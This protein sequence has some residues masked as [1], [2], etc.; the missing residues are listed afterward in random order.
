MRTPT[1]NMDATAKDQL[2]INHFD[3]RSALRLQYRQCGL[4]RHRPQALPELAD[5]GASQRAN[6]GRRRNWP[7]AEAARHREPQPPSATFLRLHVRLRE[8]SN[9]SSSNKAIEKA[10]SYDEA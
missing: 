4:R 1:A 10:N 7:N 9:I 2:D 3:S 6:L 8:E 5:P